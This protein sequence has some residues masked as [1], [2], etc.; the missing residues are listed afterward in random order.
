MCQAF[1][2]TVPKWSGWQMEEVVRL[3]E[4]VALLKNALLHQ[5]FEAGKF[6]IQ[7]E[8]EKDY[9]EWG[10]FEDFVKGELR[11]KPRTAYRLMFA[12]RMRELFKAHGRLLPVSEGSVRPLSE[13]REDRQL[14][15]IKLKLQE[16]HLKA[17]DN[18]VLMKQK[19]TPTGTDVRRAVRRL[20]GPKVDTSTDPA[21]RAYRRH[22]HRIGTE[23]ATATKRM[24]DLAAFL[25]DDGKKTK[26]QKKDLAKL[27]EK[28]GMSLIN[29]H[30][31]TLDG[32][33]TPNKRLFEKGDYLAALAKV[34]R[35][36]SKAASLERMIVILRVRDWCRRS[37]FKES[38]VKS[39]VTP[40]HSVPD[41]AYTE[42]LEMWT[43]T[44][45]VT[46]Q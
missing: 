45:G 27:I 8:Q 38:V 2:G 6:L 17:W 3:A 19:S 35:L 15:K 25:A 31:M 39:L 44:V 24:P 9:G 32:T 42:S 46:G 11:I 26:R 20:M 4:I 5:S 30:F 7:L 37:G 29:D 33:W 1:D 18:A 13:L 23:L 43:K 22:F 28:E 16:L 14:A 36:E 21:F 40:D 34:R 12:H 10:T 41:I